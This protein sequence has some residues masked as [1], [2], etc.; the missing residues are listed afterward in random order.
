MSTPLDKRS[1]SLRGAIPYYSPYRYS[2]FKYRVNYIIIALM[3]SNLLNR[4]KKREAILFLLLFLIS[5]LSFGLGYLL[6]KQNPAP[7]IIENEQRVE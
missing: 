6:A 7:I 4:L 1:L 3:L 5:S 2:I